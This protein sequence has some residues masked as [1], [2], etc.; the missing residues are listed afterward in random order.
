VRL[1]NKVAIITGGGRGIGRAI[2]Q[3]YAEEGA[4][5]I[6][7][8]SREWPEIQE[9]ASLTGGMAIQADVTKIED[10]D[11]VVKTTL[12]A[13][14]RIDILINN[15]A[16]GMRFVSEDFMRTPALFWQTDPEIWRR[17]MDTNING[18]FLMTR[19]VVPVMLRQHYGRIINISINH[20]TMV[21]KGFSPYGPSKAAL[22]AMSTIWSKELEGTG[23]TLNMLLPGGATR[24]GMV[25][26]SVS[27]DQLARLLKPEVMA[28]AAIYLASD[29]AALVTGKRIVAVEW[30]AE[31]GDGKGSS[32]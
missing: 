13:Y 23:V 28:P 2:A 26:S 15:A 20:Q 12:S 30:N 16:R 32:E 24:T 7:T 1:K 6:V 22:E 5:L 19:E 8:A 18:V 9:V 3:A 31:H 14:G 17:I 11:K 10:V 27:Q 21:R 25:P 29:E 4:H